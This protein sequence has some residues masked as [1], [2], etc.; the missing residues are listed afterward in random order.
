MRRWVVKSLVKAGVWGAGLDTLLVALRRSIR[1]HDTAGFP[2]AELES[3]MAARGKDLSFSLEEVDALSN[4]RY[5]RRAFAVLALLYP[6]FDGTR[7]FHIDHVFPSALFKRKTLL[8]AG[9]DAAEVEECI[10][11][12]DGLANL[13]LLEGSVNTSKQAS[14]PHAWMQDHFADE[15]SRQAYLAGHDLAGLPENFAG[16][17]DFYENRRKRVET[18]LAKELGGGL[19]TAG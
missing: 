19:S 2:V 9:L 17:L 3:A 11:R 4:I 8:A 18:Q 13:Q 16:F 10:E 1:E 14:M 7:E 12:R 6:G 15:A 5:G